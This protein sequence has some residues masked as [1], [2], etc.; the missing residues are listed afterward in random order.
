MDNT[1]GERCEKTKLFQAQ[2]E[3]AFPTIPVILWDERMSTIAAERSLLEADISRKKR[4]NIIDKMA[5][6]YILQ[7]YLDKKQNKK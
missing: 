3:T 6:V 4:K 1:E 7:G 5:A 2:L